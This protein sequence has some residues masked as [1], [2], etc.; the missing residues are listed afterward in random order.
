MP[1]PPQD[2]LDALPRL[3][4]YARFLIED[5]ARAEA[6]VERAITRARH[7]HC[8][9]LPG[10]TST[11]RL[12]A[13]LRS[14]HAEQLAA[15]PLRTSPLWSGAPPTNPVSHAGATTQAAGSGEA[16]DF[17]AQLF[18]LP[19]EQREA[20][21]LVAVERMSYED[22]AALLGVPVATVFARLVQARNALRALPSHRLSTPKTGG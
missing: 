22:T 10:G 3:R 21:V 1:I 15:R 11:I 14:V 8:D 5:A 7:G 13:L 4:R 16:G 2:L 9:S 18:G 19:V 20:L 12:L 17:L 6:V